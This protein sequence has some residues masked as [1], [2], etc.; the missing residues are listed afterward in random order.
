MGFKSNT[1]Q[2][3]SYSPQARSLNRRDRLIYVTDYDIEKSIMIGIDV[4]NGQ[5][6]EATIDPQNV[7]R[8]REREKKDPKKAADA[9]YLGHSVDAKMKQVIEPNG[10]HIAVL[11]GAE[12]T[13][14]INKNIDGTPQETRLVRCQRISDG[15]VELNKTFEALITLTRNARFNSVDRVQTWKADA[16]DTSNE[17]TLQSIASQFEAG[18]NEYTQAQQQIQ[19]G[20]KNASYLPTLGAELRT[21]KMSDN[22][23]EGGRII[24][25]S[26]RIERTR[27]E[28]DSETR[29][30]IRPSTPIDG[31]TFLQNAKDYIEYVKGA[32]GQDVRV[33]VAL[34]TS[35]P[36]GRYNSDFELG[37]VTWSP[38]LQLATARSKI[39]EDEDQYQE[40][41]NYGCWGVVSLSKD[42]TE[43]DG[44]LIN[45]HFVNRCHLSSNNKGFI[46]RKIKSVDGVNYDLDDSL[47]G[48]ILKWKDAQ[49]AAPMNTNPMA[50]PA[51]QYQPAPQGY[52]RDEDIPFEQLSTTPP[53]RSQAPQPAQPAARPQ[54]PAAFDGGGNWDDDIPFDTPPATVRRPAP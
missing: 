38:A 21:I 3:S 41:G 51:D 48:P 43:A 23:A 31:T 26:G 16:F 25:L 17:D 44:S 24:D 52:G 54:Q 7:A 2:S 47:K 37:G 28:Y 1:A 29:T 46:H 27:F 22:P 39:A 10:R 19:D 32:Y 33:E 49:N 34:Y 11:E 12:V 14:K 15:G 42:K 30:V 18:F 20:Q 53:A 50:A 9:S 13:R 8:G 36:T 40:G 35:Y 5:H 4:S 45:R 6:I